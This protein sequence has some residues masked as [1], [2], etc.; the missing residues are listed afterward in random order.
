M[1]SGQMI[2]RETIWCIEVDKLGGLLLLK[3][4]YSIFS[5]M[6]RILVP[7]YFCQREFFQLLDFIYVFLPSAGD[8]DFSLNQ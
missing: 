6:V 3:W 7:L 5:D 4:S 8:F 2:S 1:I